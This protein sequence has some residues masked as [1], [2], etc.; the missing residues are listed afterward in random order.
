M[1]KSQQPF[2]RNFTTKVELTKTVQ[3][4]V[5]SRPFE[6]E[7]ESELLSDLIAERHWHCSFHQLRPTKF[8]KSEGWN[9]GYDFWGWFEP[10]GWHKVSWRK[11]IT[12]DKIDNTLKGALRT[13]IL[14]IVSEYKYLH[15]FCERCN[16]HPIEHVHHVSPTFDEMFRDAI[17]VMSIEE[18][19]QIKVSQD[20]N[21]EAPFQL[22]RDHPAVQSIL[23]SH[24]GAQLQAVCKDCHPK[25]ER[26]RKRP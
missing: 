8:K 24:E 4:I 7:F 1:P 6:V 10:T 17:S 16:V 21:E 13:A 15:L 2:W 18:K 11:C 22:P 25:N 9:G 20:W 5:R 3:N 14:P 12:P 19:E 26:D 23:R